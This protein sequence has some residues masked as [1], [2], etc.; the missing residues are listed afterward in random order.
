MTPA[1]RHVRRVPGGVALSDR[2][3]AELL[4]LLDDPARLAALSPLGSTAASTIGLIGRTVMATTY[5]HE[6]DSADDTA[7][8]A[9]SPHD[10]LLDSD[11]AATRL[12]CGP[13][14]V[15]DLAR[16]GRLPG[17]RVAGRWLFRADVVD[18][19]RRAG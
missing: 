3:C 8:T 6:S 14:N 1:D 15:R 12:G 2:V 5:G 18:A 7:R 10:D 17:Q 19:H 13:A 11:G 16:R 9:P 4:G